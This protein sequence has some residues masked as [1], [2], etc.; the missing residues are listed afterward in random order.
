MSR[1]NKRI[2]RLNVI[3]NTLPQ[4]A[5]MAYYTIEDPTALDVED[6]GP[7]QDLIGLEWSAFTTAA[8]AKRHL[9]AKAGRSR[10]SWNDVNGDGLTLTAAVE[11]TI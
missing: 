1:K 5:W 3:K 4:G 11:V 7:I 10:V 8:A 2:Y 9:A 6:G